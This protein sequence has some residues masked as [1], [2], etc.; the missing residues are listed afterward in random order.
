[1]IRR[2][3]I[4]TRTATLLPYTTL[5]PS[6]AA[7]PSAPA[8]G[9]N[10]GGG[11]RWPDKAARSWL[12]RPEKVVGGG[13]NIVHRRRRRGGGGGGRYRTVRKRAKVGRLPLARVEAALQRPDRKSTRLNS[14]HQ[15]ASRMPYSA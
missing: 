15:C 5:F 4:A 8:S 9:R 12:V 14:S 6:Q 10:G 3:L 13:R 7:A 11:C 1:M 2:P